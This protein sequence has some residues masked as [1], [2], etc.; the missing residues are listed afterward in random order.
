M[1]RIQTMMLNMFPLEWIFHLIG[2]DW[3]PR[4]CPL[5]L[6]LRD[7]KSSLVEKIHFIIKKSKYFSD[8]LSTSFTKDDLEFLSK[9][10]FN[11]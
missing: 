7:S 8:T 6:E 4:I 2:I 3:I 1:N 9:I 5:Y 11:S 10:F